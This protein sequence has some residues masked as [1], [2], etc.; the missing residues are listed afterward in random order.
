MPLWDILI[1]KTSL[2]T[3][4]HY[5]MLH[6]RLLNPITYGLK[7]SEQF[8]LCAMAMSKLHDLLKILVS[9]EMETGPC[10]VG[11]MDEFCLV[12]LIFLRAALI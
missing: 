7:Q 3:K 12:G 4:C 11:T 6:W 8:V 9:R 2:H 1:N 10:G 5:S